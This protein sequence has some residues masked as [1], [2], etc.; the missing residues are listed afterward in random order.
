MGLFLEF[1][2]EQWIVASAL[3]VCIALLIRHESA[4]GGPTLS[5]QQLINQVN[6]QQAVVVDLRDASEFGQGHIVDAVN[7]PHAKLAGRVSELASY[8][9]R[10]IVL[11]CKMGQH[12][13]AAGK[14][15]GAQ[16]F[17][18]IS[19]LSGGIMEW[20]NLQLPLITK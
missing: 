11:V 15:L 16:G 10:P 12:S 3:A 17:Q 5:P 7:I 4:K 14:L 1:I 9:D 18:Q 6:Q 13:G 19:R 2:A 8:K 20:K